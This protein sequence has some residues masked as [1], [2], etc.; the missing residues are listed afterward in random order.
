MKI[1]KDFAKIKI[2]IFFING[3]VKTDQNVSTRF[4][5]VAHKSTVTHEMH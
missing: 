4:Y 3:S 1:D 2:Y 5:K